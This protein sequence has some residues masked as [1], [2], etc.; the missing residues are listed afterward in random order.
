M[1]SERPII[2]IIIRNRNEADYLAQV[3]RA[4]SLQARSAYE[5]IIVDN[6]SSD[7]SI[8]VAKRAGARIISIGKREFSYG[9]ALNLG[10]REASGEIIVLLSAH[11][12]P[13]G[14]C[15]LDEAVAPFADSCVAA[16]SF[17]SVSNV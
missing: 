13:L 6:E 14:A 12:Y 8:E 16:V 5:V 1:P 17:R 4:L 11:S 7:D 3:L 2:S 15:F 10:V 9:K